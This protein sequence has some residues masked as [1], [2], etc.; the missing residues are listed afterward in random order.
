[1]GSTDPAGVAGCPARAVVWVALA[2]SAQDRHTPTI[3]AG[4]MARH[5]NRRVGLVGGRKSFLIVPLLSVIRF[6]VAPQVSDSCVDRA[7]RAA[8]VTAR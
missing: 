4:T 6:D 1:M 8:K 2:V 3:S 7:V 5:Q